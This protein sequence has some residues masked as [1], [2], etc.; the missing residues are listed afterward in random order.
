MIMSKQVIVLSLPKY[1]NTLLRMSSKK[2]NTDLLIKY[3]NN[4]KKLRSCV[5]KKQIGS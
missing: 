3:P 4:I 2:N 5:N 1:K